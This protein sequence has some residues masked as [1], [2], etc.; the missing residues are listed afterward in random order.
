MEPTV[1]RSGVPSDCCA[2]APDPR[3][4]RCF[5]ERIRERTREG[6]PPPLHPVSRH[7][8]DALADVDSARPSVLELG[9]GSGALTVSLLT[10]GATSVDGVDLSRASVAV[11]RAR[12]ESAG[13]ADLTSFAV[14][15]AASVTLVERDWVVLDR[16]IC[17][18]RD[19]DRL[20]S[21]SSAAARRRYAFTV[22]VSHG[23]RGAAKRAWLRLEAVTSRWRGRPCPG[24]VHD[25][26]RIE[27]TLEASGFTP[28]RRRRFGFWYVAVF[29]RTAADQRF[30][31]RS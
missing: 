7:L 17:C 1:D 29:E 12:A 26:H 16:V 25:V 4:A 18:Y 19:V 15:D 31:Q 21:R 13:V 27:R 2:T 20:G 9:C 14:G 23:W 22:P 5:D 28:L 24:Y 11:A 10:S 6:A 3:I 30:R 8:L